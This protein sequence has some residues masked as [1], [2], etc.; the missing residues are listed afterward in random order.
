VW[1]R[2]TITW[3][4]GTGTDGNPTQI[5]WDLSINGGS[6]YTTAPGGV[7]DT[8]TFTWD[9]SGNLTATTGAAGTD[10]WLLGLLG[11]VKTLSASYV[12]HA[13]ASGTSV[14]GLSTLSTM[15]AS[16]VA[17]TGG[18]IDGVSIGSTTPAVARFTRATEEI[19]TLQTPSSNAAVALDWSKGNSR[20]TNSGTNAISFTNV[21]AAGL[22]THMVY[23]SNF[24]ACTWPASLPNGNWGAGGKPSFATAAWVALWS[25]DGGTTVYGAVA[26]K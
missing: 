22:A 3:G 11:R 15:L 26:W 19:N 4:A 7:I 25:P 20:V 21:A 5:V 23:V 1:L 13:A 18:T 2:A 17:F 6:D 16:A 24:N 10:S 8:Q 12:A 14:H 9:S